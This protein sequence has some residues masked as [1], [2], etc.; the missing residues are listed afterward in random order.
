MTLT[1]TIRNA[2][3]LDNGQPTRFVLNRRG[4]VIGRAATC[5]WSLPDP[6]NYISSRHAEI[7]FRDGFYWF[8]DPS[9][10][11]T[12]L[13]GATDRMV[14]VRRI[15][16]GDLFL[17][18]QY[19]VVA[20]LS[21]EALAAVERQG[22]QRAAEADA[23]AGWSWDNG[24]RPTAEPDRGWGQAPVAGDGAPA[25]ADG[26]GA[27]AGSGDWG[28]APSAAP[29]GQ[30]GWAPQLGPSLS[31]P[32]PYAGPASSPSPPA[33][34]GRASS[35]WAP[36]AQAPEARAPS[37]WDAAHAPVQASSPWS[38]AAPDRPRDPTPNDIW[39]SMEN[40]NVVDWARA[41]FGAAPAARAD[42]LGLDRKPADALPKER[43]PAPIVAPPVADAGWAAPPAPQAAGAGWAP[44]PAVPAPAVPPPAALPAAPDL[45]QAALA[46]AIA[47]G[48]QPDQLKQ[49]SPELL[50]RAGQLMRRLVSGLVV[51]VEARAR[52]KAQLGAQATA[53]EFDGNNPIKFARAPDQAIAALLNPPERGF[54]DAE[55]AIED[56]FHDLQSHQMATLKAMQGALRATLDRF[57]PEAI[58]RRAE[59]GGFLARLLPGGREATL[60]ATYEREF[61]GVAQGSDEAFMDVFAKEFRQAYEAQSRRRGG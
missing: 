23:R 38:S 15:E 24:A 34:D 17:I 27:G 48:L 4:A 50:A 20:A 5:D 58:K 44:T 49:P 22:E 8:A 55:R 11:G 6:R 53:L 26:W 56:A 57:S 21:G 47:A 36:A 13:N 16:E 51:M 14:D 29:P 61:S 30:G 12:F 52:A 59:T 10:N 18:G 42:P 2:D 54:M 39:G 19:E 32:A 3:R 9:T 41:N 35:G 33:R 40:S 45:A 46:F 37:P 1:L 31:A 25:P 7:S 60:W 28:P 43:P